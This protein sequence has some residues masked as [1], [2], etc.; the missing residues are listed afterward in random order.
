MDLLWIIGW[1]LMLCLAGYA[2]LVLYATWHFRR[3]SAAPLQPD[4]PFVSVI[5]PARNEAE[6]LA[7]CL[8]SLFRQQYPP[9]RFELLLVDDHSEDQ[10]VMVA[11]GYKGL[12]MMT[13]NGTGKKAALATGIA[14]AR[15][16]WIL[17]IDADCVAPPGW[18]QA[19]TAWMTSEKQL[20]SGPVG[21]QPGSSWLGRLQ[22]LESLGLVTLGAGCLLGGI[23]N[24]ANGA[25]LAY[26]RSTFFELGGFQ[27]VDHI[28]SGDD[29]FLLQKFFQ[30]DPGGLAFAKDPGCMV[31]THPAPDWAAFVRQRLRWVS[32]AR[33]YLVRR[34]NLIQLVSWLGFLAFPYWLGLAAAD[35]AAWGG[36]AGL[37]VIK[38]IPDAWLMYSGASFFANLSALRWFVPLQLAY[39]PYVLWIGIAGNLVRHYQW[40]DRNVA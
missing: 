11:R 17:Q 32:K 31:R 22:A 10:T 38:A 37:I 21:L 6:N 4:L 2:C 14:A 26:R 20:V 36:L 29:E 23:P 27:G 28:A 13:N 5:I 1:G 9:D 12:R 33:N 24:M 16:E 8:D 7:A 35:S 15:G 3:A 30:A 39:I 40:K 25:N 19:M 34:N 18:I